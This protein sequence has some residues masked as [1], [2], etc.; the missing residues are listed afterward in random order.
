[1]SSKWNYW[2][3]LNSSKT[4]ECQWS[5]YLDIFKYEGMVEA[6]VNKCSKFNKK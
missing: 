4:K 6:K 1:M 2:N 5:E 3:I